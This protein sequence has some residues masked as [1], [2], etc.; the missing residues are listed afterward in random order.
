MPSLP[1]RDRAYRPADS[2]WIRQSSPLRMRWKLCCSGFI[3]WPLMV[4]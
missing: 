2:D 3:R 1:D 4:S